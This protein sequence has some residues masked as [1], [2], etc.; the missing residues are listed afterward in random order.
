MISDDDSDEKMTDVLP[1]K[2]APINED[3]YEKM[4]HPAKDKNK[5]DHKSNDQ[6]QPYFL[7]NFS[8]FTPV[9]TDK[10]EEVNVSRTH[11]D[12]SHWKCTKTYER[13]DVRNKDLGI[14]VCKTQ[15]AWEDKECGLPYV[16]TFF[17]AHTYEP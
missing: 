10:H 16:I 5:K 2:K 9:I 6:K 1:T 3:W 11:K 4:K 7:F 14:F 13:Y 12:N 15:M 8:N 17:N